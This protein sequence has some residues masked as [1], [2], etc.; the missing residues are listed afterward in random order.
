MI[1]R[2]GRI[3]TTDILGRLK[4]RY[5]IETTLRT[6]QRDLIALDKFRVV[7]RNLAMTS[8]VVAEDIWI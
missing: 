8:P 1:P 5:G 4:S 3:A 6:I 2:R 7:S